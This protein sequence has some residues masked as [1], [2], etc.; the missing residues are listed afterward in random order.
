MGRSGSIEER[1]R[2]LRAFSRSYTRA[3]QVLDEG[4]LS[5]PYTLTEARVLVELAHQG[6]CDATALRRDLGLD[7]SYLSRILARFEADGLVTRT[8]SSADARR[9][10]VMLTDAGQATTAELEARSDQQAR[11]LLESL[12]EHDQVR[13]VEAMA[14]IR[15]VLEPTP[16][17]GPTVVLRAPQPG[18]Y[19]WVVARHGA[20]YATEYGW[21]ATFEALVARIVADF[22]AD[23]DPVREHAWIA[24][25]DAEPVGC[26]FCTAKDD[27]VAALRILLVEPS[28]R[29]HGV[30]AALVAECVRFARAAGYQ[31][32]TL[33]TNDVLTSAR[34]IYQAAGFQLVDS[35]PHHSFGHDLVGQNWNLTL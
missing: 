3:L 21:N 18:D 34:R 15:G 13:L 31:Q 28:A 11:G 4:L 27:T 5:T 16:G 9:R 30:G 8:R 32:L 26:V 20:L 25:L 14:T 19:G 23:H 35:A 12:D 17:P 7:A 22:A 10:Q 1:V 29:G 2:A 33:W 24:E 6:G